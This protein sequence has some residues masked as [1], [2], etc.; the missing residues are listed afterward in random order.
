MA[1]NSILLL[2]D[3]E[4]SSLAE[5][6]AGMLTSF[7]VAR[8]EI[9]KQTRRRFVQGNGHYDVAFIPTTTGLQRGSFVE[10]EIEPT[11]WRGNR[12]CLMVGYGIAP[13]DGTKYDAFLAT[14]DLMT[15]VS[16]VV[17]LRQFFD[18]LHS[19]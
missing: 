18:S 5:R 16:P 15:A 13:M 8:R 9:R 19:S 12:D 17:Y 3:T 14:P 10:G 2:E 1:I 7:K 6:L 11:E 4:T